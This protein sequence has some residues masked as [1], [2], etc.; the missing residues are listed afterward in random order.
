MTREEAFGKAKGAARALIDDD[1]LPGAVAMYVAIL[2]TE[3]IDP[4]MHHADISHGQMLAT[5]QD[6]KAVREWVE[7]FA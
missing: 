3:K 5:A 6:A 4:P 2:Q 7:K 1:D